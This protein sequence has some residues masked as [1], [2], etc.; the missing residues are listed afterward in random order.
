MELKCDIQLDDLMVGIKH[1][2]ATSPA[3][4]SQQR[5]QQITVVVL[6]L[7]ATGLLGLLRSPL[8]ISTLVASLIFAVTYPALQRIRTIRGSRKIYE[9]SGEKLLGTRTLS[10][11]DRGLH[12]IS[13]LEEKTIFWDSITDISIAPEH[14]IVC[15]SDVAVF[16]IPKERILAGDF[17]RFVS[18]LDKKWRANRTSNN[19]SD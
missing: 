5:K 1:L 10:I 4:K 18:E 7:V 16:A 3:I 11:E 15:V 13:K 6:L 9:R 12:S 14:C 17:D 2:V 19:A 8:A